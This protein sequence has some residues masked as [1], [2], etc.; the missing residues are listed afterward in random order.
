MQTSWK[1][2]IPV[3]LAALV[4]LFSGCDESSWE[5]HRQTQENERQQVHAEKARALAAFAAQ[6]NATPIQLSNFGDNAF[7]AQ[8]QRKI[9]GEVVAFRANLIDVVRVSNDEYQLVLGYGAIFNALGGALAKLAYDNQ[10]IEKLLNN[11]SS[12]YLIAAKIGKVAPMTFKITPC[13]EFECESARV[14]VSYFLERLYLQ[15]RLD[16]YLL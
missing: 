10:D 13:T 12:K 1:S 15:T 2:L 3:A 6:Y 4:F 8:L 5:N 9:E 11:H 14:E 16:E 7:T